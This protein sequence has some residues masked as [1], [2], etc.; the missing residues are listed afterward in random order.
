MGKKA[1][2]E[3]CEITSSIV[4]LWEKYGMVNV[5]LSTPPQCYVSFVREPD[6]NQDQAKITAMKNV[7]KW[8]I[9]PNP[10]RKEN[11]SEMITIP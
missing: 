6:N 4:Q 3:G 5:F 2:P 1:P 7:R 10:Q 9:I 11:R 8:E